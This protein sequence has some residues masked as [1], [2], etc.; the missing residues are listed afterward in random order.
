MHGDPPARRCDR[1]PGPYVRPE[2]RRVNFMCVGRVR[3]SFPA[4]TDGSRNGSTCGRVVG[5]PPS[6]AVLSERILQLT[7]MWHVPP[8][9]CIVDY[10]PTWPTGAR[11]RTLLS[12][13]NGA[14]SVLFIMRARTGQVMK[15]V[16]FCGHARTRQF[17]QKQVSMCAAAETTK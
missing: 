17:K 11:R 4:G 14:C 5:F 13:I 7:T 3:I 10:P 6:R 1:V 9:G 2:I 12:Q 16:V 8:V 15:L